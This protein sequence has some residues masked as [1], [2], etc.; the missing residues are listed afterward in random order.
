MRDILL[1]PVTALMLGKVMHGVGDPAAASVGVTV[2]RHQRA[3][4]L[5]FLPGSPYSTNY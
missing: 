2:E 3:G 1:P 4:R 5:V